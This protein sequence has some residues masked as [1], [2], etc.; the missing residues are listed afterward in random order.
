MGQLVWHRHDI[1]NI[2]RGVELAGLQTAGQMNDAELAGYRRGF[3]AALAATATS[4]G[5]EVR[6]L[7]LAAPA[8]SQLPPLTPAHHRYPNRTG[9]R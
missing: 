1:E 2:L 8:E 3:L 6:P 9:E 7:P 4:F 5:I